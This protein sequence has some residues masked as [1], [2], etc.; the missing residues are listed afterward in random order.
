M[1][2]CSVKETLTLSELWHG[3]FEIYCLHGNVFHRVLVPSF[4]GGIILALL[5]FSFENSK[6]S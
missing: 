6:F 5:Y 1:G 4:G 2:N 3:N